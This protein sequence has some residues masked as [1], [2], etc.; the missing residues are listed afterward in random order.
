VLIA[1]C[2][3]V[4]VWLAIKAG[5]DGSTFLQVTLNGLTLAGLYFVVAAGFTL[6]FGL[7]RVVN[8]AHGSLYLFGGYLAFQAQTHWFQSSGG[9]FSLT[10]TSSTSVVGFAVPLIYATVVIGLVGLGMQ[11]ALLRWNQG[12]DLRQALITIAVSVIFADQLLAHYGGIAQSIQQPSSWPLSVTVFGVRY[13][14]FR[15]VVVL[16][17]AVVIGV[18]LYMLIKRTRFGMIVRAGVDDRSML[19]ALGVNVQLVFAGAFLIGAMLAGFAGVLGGATLSLQP[20][21]DTQF[22]LDALIVVIIGG[23]GSL[24]GAAIGAVLLGLVQSYSA[25]YLK[26]GSTDLTNYAI[27]SSF[28]L[29]IAVLAVR[30]LGLFGRPA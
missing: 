30:P 19:S 2:L 9:Q 23:M 4:V 15:L 18:L 3:A 11:Q 25:I 20:G 13:P 29:V 21:Y 8:M 10:A 26:F 1:L 28:I 16:G 12:Q 24:G 6:I 5:H 14:F 27:L 7:M 22:L 17:A